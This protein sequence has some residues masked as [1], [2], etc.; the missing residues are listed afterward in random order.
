[1]CRLACQHE[2][3]ATTQVPHAALATRGPGYNRRQKLAGR[4][5][6]SKTSGL[7]GRGS[8][9]GT[10]IAPLPAMQSAFIAAGCRTTP[11]SCHARRTQRC[12]K[13][14]AD[15]RSSHGE[16]VGS[17]QW[18]SMVPWPLVHSVGRVRSKRHGF[19]TSAS[20]KHNTKRGQTTKLWDIRCHQ[21]GPCWP[22]THRHATPTWHAS[23]ITCHVLSSSAYAIHLTKLPG[24]VSHQ[25]HC[26]MFMRLVMHERSTLWPVPQHCTGCASTQHTVLQA[27]G[28]RLG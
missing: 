25:Q 15:M 16:T 24:M 4:M 8:T 7:W 14:A 10:L 18:G 21:E 2:N 9:I 22:A 1:M 11:T 23:G 26:G 13:A 6:T 5:K 28:C 3:T 12:S 17:Q 20:G 19:K 27:A